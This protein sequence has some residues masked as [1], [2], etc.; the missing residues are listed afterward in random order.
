M[1]S[2]MDTRERWG[3]RNMPDTMRSVRQHA[4]GGPEV[5]RVDE[6]PRPTP[7]DGQVLVRVHAA[8]VNPIDWKLRTGILRELFPQ[9]LPAGVGED[10]AGVVE[11]AAGD[12][13]FKPGDAVY[14]MLPSSQT[15]AFAE[16]VV[17]D[18][19]SLAPQPAGIGH[20]RSAAVPMGALTA[21]QG[22]VGQGGL[23][24]G[25]RVL[26]HGAAGN[27]GGMAVQIARALGAEVTAAASADALSRVPALGAGRTVP[28]ADNVPAGV[29]PGS[30][31]IVFD[32]LGGPIQEA[33]WP[34]L[35]HGGILVTTLGIADPSRAA[36]SGVRASGFGAVPDGNQLR[37]VAA[38]VEAGQVKVVVG[39]T[40][41]LAEAGQAQELNR[42]GKVKGKVVVVVPG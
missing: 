6:V 26:V 31:D 15:G 9:T 21:W 28:Y 25:M 30:Q 34:L 8:S 10:F 39:R 23:K 32:T 4:Y 29:E 35:K 37:Q 13:G 41:P 3:K 7:R 5:L 17:I 18:A 19:G 27:V 14:G 20:E 40:L 24:A 42:T 36:Q 16:Y 22:I 11:Q 12:T 38:M 2:R 1:A 33:S